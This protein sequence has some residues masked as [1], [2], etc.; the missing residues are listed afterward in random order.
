MVYSVVR[1]TDSNVSP[2]HPSAE[3][4]G[5]SHL[6]RFAD[7]SKDTFATAMPPDVRKGSALPPSIF[8]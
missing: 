3:A 2:R 4:L 8:S 5:S 1:F 7:T 6:V